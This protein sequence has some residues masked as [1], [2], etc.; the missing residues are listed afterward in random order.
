M[1]GNR[2]GSYTKDPGV[3]SSEPISDLG[4]RPGGYMKDLGGTTRP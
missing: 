1:K 4:I 2:G 3:V